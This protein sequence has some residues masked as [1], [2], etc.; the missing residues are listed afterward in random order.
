MLQYEKLPRW[1]TRLQKIRRSDRV[2]L[3]LH[4][5]SLLQGQASSRARLDDLHPLRPLGPFRL[6]NSAG[7]NDKKD[8]KPLSPP[9]CKAPWQLCARL[10]GAAVLPLFTSA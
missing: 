9:T 2:S 10:L 6:H 1:K 7:N 3:S 5:A 4:L 8:N